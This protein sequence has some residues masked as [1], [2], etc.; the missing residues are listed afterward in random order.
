MRYIVNNQFVQITAKDKNGKEVDV[1]ETILRQ[2]HA[3]CKMLPGQS[4]ELSDSINLL[5]DNETV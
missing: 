4:K 1:I 3:I 2:Q 5:L